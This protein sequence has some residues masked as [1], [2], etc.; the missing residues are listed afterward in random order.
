MGS[1]PDY[2]PLIQAARYLGVPPWDL[3]KQSAKWK[4]WALICM[5]AEREGPKSRPEK[6]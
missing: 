4:D 5:T 1:V 6:G 2:Y 3:L